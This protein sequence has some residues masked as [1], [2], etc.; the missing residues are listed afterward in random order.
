MY[1][2]DVPQAS[3]SRQSSVCIDMWW[4][5]SDQLLD[6]DWLSRGFVKSVLCCLSVSVR[7]LLNQCLPATQTWGVKKKKKK[8]AAV[9]TIR[10]LTHHDVLTHPVTWVVRLLTEST[11][12]PVDWKQTMH[13][14]SYKLDRIALLS[15]SWQELNICIHLKSVIHFTYIIK[16][17]SIHCSVKRAS[18]LV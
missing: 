6:L 2:A 14:L 9:I 17:F 7:A 16:T 11:R 3:T 10:L 5:K 15:D 4:E 12:I 8:C 1:C 18:V 13:M